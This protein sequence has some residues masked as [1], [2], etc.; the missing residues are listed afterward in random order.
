[1]S[2]LPLKADIVQQDRDVRFVP[3]ADIPPFAGER[4]DCTAKTFLRSP[5]PTWR[6]GVRIRRRLSI[7]TS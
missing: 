6:E 4:L 3:K 2:A 7:L 5:R 1:M